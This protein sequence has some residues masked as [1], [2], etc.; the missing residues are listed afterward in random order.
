MRMA[1]QDQAQVFTTT[2]WSI[3]LI[4]GLMTGCVWP[5]LSEPN[6]QLMR[7]EGFFESV[8]ET[9]V[10]VPSGALNLEADEES[11]DQHGGSTPK[12]LDAF[13]ISRN[14]ISVAQYELFREARAQRQSGVARSEADGSLPATVTWEEA[15]AYAQWASELSGLSFRLPTELEWVYVASAGGAF[16][17][18]TQ[19]DSHPWGLQNMHGVAWEWVADCF[20]TK[21]ILGQAHEPSGDRCETSK[22]VL[23]GGSFLPFAAL[24][25]ITNRTSGSTENPLHQFGFRLVLDST[26]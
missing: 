11:L 24:S 19:F 12:E 20:D 7:E 21:D 18:R 17:H 6:A 13:R 1:S 23:R 15:R 5:Q 2:P 8:V 9:M 10:E 26:P 14:Q 4:L 3:V 22:R 16:T 25:N